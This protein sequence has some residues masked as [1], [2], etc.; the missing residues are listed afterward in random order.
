MRTSAASEYNRLPEVLDALQFPPDVFLVDST[1][2]SLQSG[3]SG[4]RHDAADLVAIGLAL[5]ELG[6]RELIV[7]ISWRDGP[8]VVTGLAQARPHAR[9]VATFR[10]RN[11]KADEWTELS[12]DSG[13]DEICFESAPDEDYLRRAAERV[14]GRGREVSHG[15][16]E[17]YTYD[18]VVRLSRVATEC[19]YRSLAFHDSFFRLGIS[20]DGIRYFIRS[21]RKD[22]PGHPALYVHLSDFYGHATM[23]GIAALSAGA[24]AVDVC[25]NGTGHHCGHTSLSEVAVALED[26]Y[27]VPTGIRLHRLNEVAA[28]VGERTGVPQPL[29]QP[30][31]GE[32]AFMGDG[33]YWAAEAHLPHQDRIHARFPYPPHVV[34]AEERV[35]WHDRTA[36]LDSIATKLRALGLPGEAELAIDVLARLRERLREVRQYPN[37]LTDQE[38]SDL[39]RATASAA[40]RGARS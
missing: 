8:E 11:P 2:R 4:S 31:I 3:V 21:V 25:M 14:R 27:G 30:V 9:I 29:D 7:N 5:D 19:G 6:V 39:A 10:A 38:F 1:I 13:A 34:G 12:L 26:F 24:S 17:I 32:F 35:V 18:E 20:P 15:F 23:T 37:W 40:V 33:A 36:T 22:V 16:A 28:L